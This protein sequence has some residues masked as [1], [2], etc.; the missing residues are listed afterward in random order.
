MKANINIPILLIGL[1]FGIFIG[2]FIKDQLT[3][4]C[5][6]TTV[7]HIS[8]KGVKSKRGSSLSLQSYLE[9][10]TQQD[11]IIKKKFFKKRKSK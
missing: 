4:N 3:H 5:P 8:Y 11:T 2:Y 9:S 6:P 10:N 1:G 7:N